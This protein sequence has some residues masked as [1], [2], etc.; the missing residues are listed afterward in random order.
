MQEVPDLPEALEALCFQPDALRVALQDGFVDEEADLLDLGHLQ[1]LR[2][3]E[4]R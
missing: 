4:N 3:E 1:P 2:R